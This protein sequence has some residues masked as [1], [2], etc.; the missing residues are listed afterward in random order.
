MSE[1]K[2]NWKC[3]F[4]MHQFSIIK[5]RDLVTDYDEIKGRIYYLQCNFCGTIKKRSL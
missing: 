4:G 3:L 5:E 2:R 1:D